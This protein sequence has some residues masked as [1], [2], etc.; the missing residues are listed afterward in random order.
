MFTIKLPIEIEQGGGCLKTVILIMQRASLAQ[1]LIAKVHNNSDI[2]LCYEPN[3]NNANETIDNIHANGALLEVSEDGK[4]DINYCLALCTGLRKT[5]PECHLML[6][7]P[8]GQIET[9]H[10]A[11]EAKR[12]GDINDFVFYN[13]SLDYLIACL[14]SL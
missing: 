12:K 2:M 1:G 9:I 10:R 14:Q 4:H 11:I 8:E 5:H 3:Y 6:M 7:C 13:A